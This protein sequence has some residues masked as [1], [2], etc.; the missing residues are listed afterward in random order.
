MYFQRRITISILDSGKPSESI[1]NLISEA[2]YVLV[3]AGAG[4]ST[5]GGL[6]YHDPAF[7][8]RIFPE[9]RDSGFQ[10]VW[11]AVTH[12]WSEKRTNPLEFWGY[13][14]RHIQRIRYDLPAASV[15]TGLLAMI[16][17]KNYFVIT[18]NVDGQFFKAGFEPASLFHPQGDYALFQ[19]RRP[20]SDELYDNQSMVGK[21]LASIDRRSWLIRPADVPRCPRCGDYMVR[22]L[23]IDESFVEKP[24]MAAE[25]RYI[26]FINSSTAGRLLL[27][28]L[29][30][31]FNTPGVIRWPFEEFVQKHPSATLVRVNRDHPE[32]PA[33]LAN[34]VISLD[35]DI[36]EVLK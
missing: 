8:A 10:T 34:R 7:F 24:H 29:G 18:T 5:A 19:C 21:M 16:K 27:L 9:M 35:N 22:N 17:N 28:E 32:Y 14:A 30:V 3:G 1:T 4:L 23:R 25:P 15:Y 20:C 2:E 12:Y 26:D 11:Q 36:A 6:N 13:W 31:G 33:E